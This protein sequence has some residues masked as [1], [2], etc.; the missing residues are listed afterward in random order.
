LKIKNIEVIPLTY[1]LK[2]EEIW[3]ASCVYVDVWNYL[4]VKVNTDEGVYGLGESGGG[5]YIPKIGRPVIDFFSRFLVGQEIDDIDRIWRKLYLSS[6]YWGR[7]GIAVS[8]IGAIETALWDILGKVQK[9]PLYELIGGK[10]YDKIRVYASG[11]M[12]KPIK[13]LVAEVEEY[14]ENGFS[15]VKIRGGYGR[16]KD[17]GL[18]REIRKA[19]G[20]NFDLML[21][22][23]QNYVPYN[24]SASEALDIC[25]EL[26]QYRLFFIEE[27][28]ITDDLEGYSFLKENSPVSIAMGENGSTVYEFKT[29]IDN[30]IADIYQPDVTNVGGISQFIK[31][32]EYAHKKNRKIA[33]HVF[34][35]GVSLM[36]H[37]YLL[38]SISNPLMLEYCRIPNPLMFD[39][40]N[41]RPELKEGYIYIPVE[42]GLG[43]HIDD[44]ILEKYKF[45]DKVQYF[46]IEKE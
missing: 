15:A 42:N 22:T 6:H 46:K 44:S 9:K 7:R 8:I 14:L 38:S 20:Y 21:D 31:V 16:E 19:L 41:S 12:Q 40:L 27:P 23:G 26:E 3:Q 32:A 45:Q 35:S 36:A 37:L 1:R 17:I 39:L 24:W 2:K 34:R 43:V 4:L 33:P 5:H 30:D 28:Y 25:R 29:F 11:G 10:K 13:D 18:V